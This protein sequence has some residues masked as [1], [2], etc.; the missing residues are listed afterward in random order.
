[1]SSYANGCMIVILPEENIGE[2]ERYFDQDYEY[3]FLNTE[4]TL[5]DSGTVEKQGYQKRI[6]D[7]SC[8][9]S[10]EAC[11]IDNDD[12]DIRDVCKNLD[13]SYMDI[14]AR[15]DEE[16][17]NESIKYDAQD[18]ICRYDVDSWNDGKISYNLGDKN[19][20]ELC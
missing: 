15:N 18:G 13:I 17:F 11:L 2:F 19:E 20:T 6:Y 5:T 14:D 7:I 16:D 4:I 3:G 9:T 8:N 10:L 1:M 12:N